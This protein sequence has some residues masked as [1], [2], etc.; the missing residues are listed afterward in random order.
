MQILWQCDSDLDAVMARV[1]GSLREGFKVE[2]NKKCGNFHTR[3]YHTPLHPPCDSFFCVEISTL[4]I[5]YFMNPPL[6]EIV[7]QFAMLLSTI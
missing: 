6:T 7:L 4:F 2:K 5:F 3:V 1:S